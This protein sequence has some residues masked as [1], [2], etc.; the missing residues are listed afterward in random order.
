MMYRKNTTD[1]YTRVRHT[2]TAANPA[3][4]F[5]YRSCQI[6]LEKVPVLVLVAQTIQL[7][8]R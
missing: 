4:Y 2:R 8:G 6:L 3:W 5:V 7:L 1:M